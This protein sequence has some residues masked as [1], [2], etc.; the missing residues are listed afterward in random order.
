M[1]GKAGIRALGFEKRLEMGGD[2]E[3][4]RFLEK[5]KKRERKGRGSE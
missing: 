4:A 5:L 1:R 2:S 3:W